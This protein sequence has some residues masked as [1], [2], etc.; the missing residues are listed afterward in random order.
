MPRM[1]RASHL[2][3]FAALACFARFA[4]AQQSHAERWLD[5]CRNHQDADERYCEVRTSTVAATPRLS[6]DGRENGSVS[7]H[8]WDKSQI[9]IVAMIEVQDRDGGDGQ[10]IA[11]DISIETANGDVHAEGPRDLGRR[12]NWAVSYEVWVPRQTELRLDAHNGGISLDNVDARVEMETMNGGI[13]LTDVAGDVR[14]TTTNGGVSAD[15]S[16]DKWNGAGLD[17]RTTN[18]SVRLSVPSTYNARLETGT[19]NGGMNIDF[20]VTVQ[21]SIRREITTQLGNGGAAIRAMTTNG[22]VSI[23]RK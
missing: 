17:L 20:P 8:G 1:L 23:R 7:V 9:Q 16:G 10:A 3:A 14:G 4:P 19:V 22:S 13:R 6:V 12:R 11:K 18:G 5:D 15:L 2:A 21:G